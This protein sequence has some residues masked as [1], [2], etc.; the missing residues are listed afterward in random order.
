MSALQA[1]LSENWCYFLHIQD[2]ARRLRLATPSTAPCTPAPNRNLLIVR[3]DIH[4]ASSGMF[5]SFEGVLST[6]ATSESTPYGI[7]G[8]RKLLPEVSGLR[9]EDVPRGVLRRQPPTRRRWGLLKSIMPSSASPEI[10]RDL[11]PESSYGKW[12]DSSIQNSMKIWPLSS[13]ASTSTKAVSDTKESGSR[14][15]VRTHQ[16]LSFRFSLEWME[17]D[18]NGASRDRRLHPPQLPLPARLTH[19]QASLMSSDHTPRQPE[20]VAVGPSKYAGRALAE[21]ADLNTECQNFFKRRKAEGISS[22]S[23]VETPMLSVDPFRKT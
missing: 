4:I 19:R 9:P 17:K 14:S 3:D 11:S 20:G 12:P 8:P 23:W 7:H 22:H 6:T 10:R 5:L 15:T 18:D 16:A 1:R 21:W 2:R 13:P